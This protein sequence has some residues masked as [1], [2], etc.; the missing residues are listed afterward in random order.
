M[1]AGGI[2]DAVATLESPAVITTDARADVRGHA[3]QHRFRAEAALNGQIGATALPGLFEMQHRARLEHDGTTQ[4]DGDAVGLR[5]QIGA[6]DGEPLGLLDVQSGAAKGDF[7]QGGVVGIAEQVVGH[8]R[9]QPIHGAT[10]ADPLIL[11][12]ASAKILEA[13]DAGGFK[14]DHG[15]PPMAT[16]SSKLTR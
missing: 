14:D 13:T 9:S 15:T 4:V 12:T 2:T 6:G 5:L 16:N 1:P 11:Q 10:D 7:D 3:A 8:T